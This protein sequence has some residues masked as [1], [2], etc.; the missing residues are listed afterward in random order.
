MKCLTEICLE[1]H[2]SEHGELY[3]VMK[4][5]FFIC[6]KHCMI[7]ECPNIGTQLTDDSFFVVLL[8]VDP[9]PG[10]K[11]QGKPRWRSFQG[12]S[13]MACKFDQ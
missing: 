6:N 10:L 11:L 13:A 8:L 4:A 5:I 7:N 2:T 9:R 3:R 1:M 12:D